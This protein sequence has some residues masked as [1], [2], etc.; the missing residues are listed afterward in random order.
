[1]Y[2]I[3][4]FFFFLFICCHYL[5][6]SLPPSFYSIYRYIF[7]HLYQ[8]TTFRFT[9]LI[10]KYYSRFFYSFFLFGTMVSSLSFIYLTIISV[11][12]LIYKQM[13][14]KEIDKKIKTCITTHRT[15]EQFNL[16]ESNCWINFIFFDKNICTY[17]RTIL[18]VRW[19]ISSRDI[20]DRIKPSSH[21]HIRLLHNLLVYRQ[22]I[23]DHWHLLVTKKKV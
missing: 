20:G 7:L 21:V 12:S 1:M 15:G 3:S 5:S 13:W 23:D 22:K 10:F 4:A 17:T 19:H 14:I 18:F 8:S 6:C 16:K 2:E 9:A 11:Y